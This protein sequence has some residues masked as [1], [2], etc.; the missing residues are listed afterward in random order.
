MVHQYYR[1]SPQRYVCDVT[2][3]VD[4]RVSGEMVENIFN[5]KIVVVDQDG[6]LMAETLRNY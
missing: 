5:M 3:V 2:Y 4:I 1:V 6:H